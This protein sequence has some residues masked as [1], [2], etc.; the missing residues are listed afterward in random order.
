MTLDDRLRTVLDVAADSDEGMRS[1]YRQ[2]VDILGSGKAVA[3][4]TLVA[5]AFLR[6][7]ALARRIPADERA[8][9]IA[10]PAVRLR[11]PPLV[12]Q[13]CEGE[14]QVAGA[15]I[16]AAEL[17]EAGWTVLVG[18]L[19]DDL[20][21][22]VR[23][24]R[25]DERARSAE[26]RGEVLV[27][28]T[29]SRT[30]PAD[31]LTPSAPVPTR[32]GPTPISAEPAT[33]IGDIVARIERFRLQRREQAMRQ[34]LGAGDPEPAEV[35]EAAPPPLAI[36]REIDCTISPEGRIGP[37][38][39]LGPML[40]GLL[41]SASADAAARLDEAT[42]TALRRQQAV[43][44]GRVEVAASPA[45]SGEWRL[46]AAPHFDPVGRFLGHHARLTRVVGRRSDPRGDLVRQ[47]LHELRTPINALQG[48]SEIIQQQL[49]GP[50]PHQY[51][52][53]AAGIAGETAA[54]LAGLEDVDRLIRLRLGSRPLDAGRTALDP[55]LVAMVDQVRPILQGRGA[56][57]VA[58]VGDAGTIV[59]V[60]E[61]DLERMIWR[62]LSVVAVSAEAGERLALATSRDNGTIA[63]SLTLSAA[64]AALDDAAFY[65]AQAGP[66]AGS[67]LAVGFLGRGFAMRLLTAEARAAGG[68]LLRKDGRLVLALPFANES[69]S[70]ESEAAA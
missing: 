67:E 3:D 27:Q 55:L 62:L 23:K 53:L 7:S 48:F 39:H 13:L 60:A 10:D 6:L 18:V 25:T 59:P 9:I 68:S 66:D 38:S 42:A 8:A 37:T 34:V 24:I 47:A 20:R 40:S 64:L 57:L 45:I 17:D 41:L 30:S 26:D 63:L 50:V 5:A 61:P 33:G 65:G 35:E 22:K 1:Q 4:G 15:A 43:R 14:D 11:S 51:R 16:A 32:V 21:G 54:L 36:P 52:S 31:D 56:H 69:F 28:R 29:A 49:F 58:D 70:E 44:N 12:A 2:L 46:D 19:D